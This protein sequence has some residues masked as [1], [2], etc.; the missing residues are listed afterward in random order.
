M[1]HSCFLPNLSKPLRSLS[2][3]QQSCTQR[4]LLWWLVEVLV[5]MVVGGAR[6]WWLLSGDNQ[7]SWVVAAVALNGRNVLINLI[8]KTKY[9]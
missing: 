4:L 1:D 5:L 9:G 8:S 2:W 6:L 7:G 3:I